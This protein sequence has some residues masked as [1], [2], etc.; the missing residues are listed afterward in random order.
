MGVLRGSLWATSDPWACAEAK[1]GSPAGHHPQ[2]LHDDPT[3]DLG[4]TELPVPECDRRLADIEPETV[5]A[6]HELDLEAVAVGGEGPAQQRVEQ[7]APIHAV[8]ARRVMDR[9]PEH[10]AGIGIAPPRER[11]A[12]AAP[13]RDSPAG[14]DRKSV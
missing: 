14:G 7:H 2:R 9:E 13:V 4:L 6:H 5:T 3:R 10:E 11:D 8:P 1:L 12:R